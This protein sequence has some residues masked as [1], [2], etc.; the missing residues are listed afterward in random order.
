[1]IRPKTLRLAVITSIVVALTLSLAALVAAD[2]GGGNRL[3]ARMTGAQEVPG[4]GDPDGR[5]HARI[6]LRPG[7]GEICWRVQFRRIGTPNRAHIHIGAAGT[8]PPANIVFPLFE[9]VGDPANPL[10]D[11]L[12]RGR[13]EGCG[14]ASEELISQIAANPANYYVNLHNTRFPGGAIRGQLRVVDDD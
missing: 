13:A 8:A 2:G 14:S 12:E 9:L 7:D 5:G 10:N 3:S 1:M 6:I 4:P 11:Q